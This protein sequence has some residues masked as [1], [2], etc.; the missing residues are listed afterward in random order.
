MLRKSDVVKALQQY[1]KERGARRKILGSE[2]N[3]GKLEKFVKDTLKIDK[4]EK[5][6]YVDDGT[7]RDWLERDQ[8]YQLLSIMMAQKTKPG[9]ASY[10][11][12]QYLFKIKK[13]H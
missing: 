2:E 4:L 7:S 10:V 9:S 13:F 11:C 1:Q 12:F 3:I 8:S 5:Y 6:E